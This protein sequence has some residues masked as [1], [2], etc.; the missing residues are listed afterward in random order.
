MIKRKTPVNSIGIAS[1]MLII[2]IV[3]KKRLR[4]DPLRAQTYVGVVNCWVVIVA[5]TTG[6]MLSTTARAQPDSLRSALMMTTNDTLKIVV[7]TRLAEYY[8]ETSPDS[9]YAYCNEL[10]RVANHLSYKL[11]EAHAQLMIGYALLNKGNY[12]RSL[13]ALLSGLAIAGDPES[14]KIKL[15]HRY[16]SQMTLFL[17]PFNTDTQRLNTVMVACHL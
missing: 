7:L 4:S 3:F 16:Y 15:S 9:S 13:R 14:D 1:L 2:T 17:T 6:L 11:D 12:P 5:V 10:A 8:C